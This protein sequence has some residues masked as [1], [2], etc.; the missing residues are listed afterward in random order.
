MVGVLADP[1][2]YAYIG[3][4]PPTPHGLSETYRRW[5]AGSPRAGEVWRNWV[6]RLRDD[7]AAVGHM[8]AT[9][10]MGDL[11]ADIGWIIGMSWQGRGYATEAALALVARLETLGVATI[12][13]LVH[14][15]NLASARVA[16]RAGFTRTDEVVDG[17][18]VWRR[19]AHTAAHAR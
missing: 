9:I 12:V 2:L 3:G 14:P 6:V 11:S 10:V 18:I 16:E 5:Q 4:Q 1:A 8:Q 13:A 7:G 17:E 19:H 15:D